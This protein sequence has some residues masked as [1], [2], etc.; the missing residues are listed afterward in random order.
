MKTF[1][2]NILGINADMQAIANDVNQLAAMSENHM[3]MIFE[4]FHALPFVNGTMM[5]QAVDAARLTIPGGVTENSLPAL[6]TGVISK[7]RQGESS[8]Q[9]EGK[10][11]L[12]VRDAL[13]RRGFKVTD[14]TGTGGEVTFILWT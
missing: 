7:A 12:E 1:L 2:R 5:L 9:V 4:T 14:E 11:S 8:L 6:L 10:L 13:L 3:R